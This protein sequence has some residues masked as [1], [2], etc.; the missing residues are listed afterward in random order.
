MTAMMSRTA[1][2]ERL[3]V[4][5][6]TAYGSNEFH[7][8][9]RLLVEEVHQRCDDNI[10]TAT[11]S[12]RIDDEFDSEEARRRYHPDQRIIVMTDDADV[13]SREILFE[14]Y[15][16]MQSWRW[17]GRIGREEERYVFHAEHVWER[18]ARAREALVFGRY[19]RNGEIDDGLQTDPAAYRGKAALL[20]ALPCVFNPDGIGNQAAEPLTV[21]AASE[22]RSVHIFTYDDRR[23][24]KWTYAT[25]IR[26]L[27]WFYLL[28]TGP[29]Y[30]GNVFEITDAPAAGLT[31]VSGALGRALA[32]EPVSLNCEATSLAEAMGL[33]CDAAGIHLSVETQNVGGRPVTQL[34]IWAAEDG[35]V[36]RLHL[37]RTGRWPDG[38]LRYDTSSRSVPD[39]L[40]ANN[41][42]RGEV[43]WDHGRIVNSPVVIGGIRKHEMT[44]PLWPG[45]IPRDGLDSVQPAGRLAAKGQ[46]LTP[47]Q[48]ESLG[49]RAEG[50]LWFRRYHR[51]GNEFKAHADTGRLWVLNEDGYYAGGLYNRNAPFD[52]YRPFDFST[53][54]DA[55]VTASGA[56]MR[57]P[58]RFLPAV[59][60]SL[61]DR[62]LGVWVEISFDTG[63][64]WQQQS[65]GVRVLEDRCA[66]YFDADNPTEITPPGADP[67]DQNMWCAIIDQAF[68]VR[69]TAVIESDD[70][71]LATIP[72][73]EVRSPTLQLNGIVVR[74][75]N[76][77]QL[78]SRSHTT[79]V[80][81][82]IGASGAAVERDDSQAIMAL[83][84]QLAEVNQDRR[85]SVAPTIPWIET[86][87]SLGDRIAEIRGRRI[88]FATTMGVETR[89]PA[90]IERRFALQDG[91]YETTL[92]LGITET[93]SAGI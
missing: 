25:A 52:N 37:A 79:N 20:T 29:V 55:T 84:R 74:R 69:V 64:T 18:L 80:L 48:V 87:Y 63:A 66:I 72:P 76:A 85:V 33:L 51:R 54:A 83:A 91:R 68:R 61:E 27:A 67:L 17:D 78:V 3:L 21:T 39:I 86:A 50:H 60:R 28:K 6:E 90:V 40:S 36:R 34:R 15:P 49:S 70:R 53:V 7:L 12:V 58:R 1:S 10:S 5:V 59:T 42:Y 93:P 14:G 41:A 30:E 22:V 2:A 88:R 35:P 57:R 56:W 89:F 38:E 82:G 9:E 26:Y 46:A 73:G 24:P 8:D 11:I 47:D 62:P 31:A 16:P 23:S 75:A 77:F 43:A 4:T 13:A 19:V 45:W 71:L 32:R 44:V 65:S 92:T 81:C